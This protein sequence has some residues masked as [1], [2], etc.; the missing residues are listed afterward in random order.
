MNSF[1]DFKHAV[2]TSGMGQ[3]TYEQCWF[4]SYTMMYTY[5]KQAVSGIEGKLAGKG[6]DVADAKANGLEDRKYY[7]A[8]TALG[9]TMWSG[10]KF[11]AEPSWYDV[12]LTDGCEAFIEEL[13]KGPLWVSRYIKS[14]LYHIVVAT[15][16]MW[17]TSGKGY[18]IYNNPYPG[19]TNAVEVTDLLAN[20][21][22]KHITSA[23]G[24]VQAF[25]S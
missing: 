18:I 3:K 4:A 15:G 11:K 8:G 2:P 13:Q 12:G 10:E 9:M 23:R 14:G 19:P 22:V 17:G 25:R 20:V 6:I 5:H 16:F 7:D 24:S 1:S 21:F